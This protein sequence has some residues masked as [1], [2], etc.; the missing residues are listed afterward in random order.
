MD[1]RI[2]IS[3]KKCFNTAFT[4]WQ[5]KKNRMQY[6]QKLLE[7][8]PVIGGDA[9][10]TFSQVI[11]MVYNPNEFLSTYFK[12][13]KKIQKCVDENGGLSC[14]QFAIF[15]EEASKQ[16]NLFRQKYMGEPYE[17]AVVVGIPVAILKLYKKMIIQEPVS[18]AG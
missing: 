12:F 5:N 7:E 8:Y 15:S 13:L 1:S 2:F 9:F 10:C 16:A 6:Q 14:D 4:G 11:E 3:L 18:K 17:Q